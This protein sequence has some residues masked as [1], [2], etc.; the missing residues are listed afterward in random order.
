LG[1]TQNVTVYD[2]GYEPRLY[3]YIS[4]GDKSVVYFAVLSVPQ[5]TYRRLQNDWRIVVNRDGFAK[6]WSLPNQGV[7]QVSD[8]GNEEPHENV[9]QDSRCPG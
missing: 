1:D 2:S 4:L 3:T 7:I 8:G 5:A 9:T 6:K